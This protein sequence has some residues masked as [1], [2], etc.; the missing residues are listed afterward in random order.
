LTN[1]TRLYLDAV[2]LGERFPDS[3]DA[4]SSEKLGGYTLINFNLGWKEGDLDIGL[5]INN[6]TNKKYSGLLFASGGYPAPER[7]VEFTLSYQLQ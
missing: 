3:D 4:N 5:R 7:N 1:N 6:M 2:Y